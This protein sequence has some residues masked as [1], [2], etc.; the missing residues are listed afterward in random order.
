M[1]TNYNPGECGVCNEDFNEEERCPRTLRC[2]HFLCS[3]CISSLIMS[4]N[5]RCP[6]CREKFRA[7]SSSDIDINYVVLDFMKYISSQESF[8]EKPPHRKETSYKTRLNDY[9]EEIAETNSELRATYRGVKKQTE[10][11]IMNTKRL[12]ELLRQESIKINE[13]V[14]PKMHGIVK[15]H[16]RKMEELEVTDKRL[17]SQ[18]KEIEVKSKELRDLKGKLNSANTFKETTGIM[19]EAERNNAVATECI[20]NFR[21]H[22]GQYEKTLKSTEEEVTATQGKISNVMALLNSQC[23]EEEDVESIPNCV[24]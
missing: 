5:K 3:E 2:S 18:L 6:F 19:D 23:D 1:A 8:P 15:R 9:K 10:E 13:E 16:Y 21:K 17:H 4:N 12:K 11:A 22:M 24:L 7:N 20:E 14:I